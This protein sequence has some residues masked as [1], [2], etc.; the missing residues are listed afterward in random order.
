M[1]L[2]QS[3][4]L[5]VPDYNNIASFTDDQEGHYFKTGYGLLL[6]GDTGL[7]PYYVLGLLNSRLLFSY[8]MHIGTKLRGGYVRFWT[9][10][11]QQLPIRT[12][13]PTNP[14]DATAHDHMVALVE[15]MLDLHQRHA[16]EANPQMKTMLQRQI[17]ATDKQID[18][19][20]YGLYGLTQEEIAIVEA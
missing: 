18:A 4:K 2:F 9:Q 7:S 19:L 6:K 20:V 14:A 3:P 10:F 11:I 16:A 12:I 8:L 13:D 5:V 1:T 15:R 17:D